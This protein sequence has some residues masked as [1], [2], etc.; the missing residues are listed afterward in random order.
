[1]TTTGSTSP[2]A[3]LGDESTPLDGVTLDA[4]RAEREFLLRSIEDLEAE[5]ADGELTSERYEDLLGAYTVQ[6]ATVIRALE[7]AEATRAAA[8][9]GAEAT[10]PASREPRWRRRALGAAMAAVLLATGGTLLVRS[11]DR[12]EVGQT[13]TGN[14]Q[15]RTSRAVELARAARDRPQD[16]QARIAYASALLGDGKLVDALKELDTAA[17]LDPGNA[18]AKAYGGWIVFLAGLTDDALRRLDAAIATDPAY[19]D[20][21]FFRGMVLLRGRND[22]AGALVEL[23]QFTRLAPPGP[24]RSSVESTIAELEAAAGQ[25]GPQPDP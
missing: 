12:R 7:R 8:G 25:A 11:L 15:S 22:S 6:A 13:I 18:E 4:L 17:R 9:E 19:A 20:A 2:R 14:A 5:W 3:E 1:M 21:H 16:P 23:R 10:Q 24:E